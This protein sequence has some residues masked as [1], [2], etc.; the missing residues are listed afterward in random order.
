MLHHVNSCLAKTLFQRG[1]AVIVCRGHLLVANRQLQYSK[2]H[3]VRSCYILFVTNNIFELRL[4]V[5]MHNVSFPIFSRT[6]A[7][8]TMPHK[9]TL[10]HVSGGR[11]LR[12]QPCAW[13]CVSRVKRTRCRASF[14]GYKWSFCRRWHG[15]HVCV[16][17]A[18][19]AVDFLSALPKI[20]QLTVHKACRRKMR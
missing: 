14:S 16:C 17:V 2:T 8:A 4:S 1:Y 5:E 11:L 15:K 18:F 7:H 12:R 6:L 3:S 9:S 13:F 10:L 19:G 20:C